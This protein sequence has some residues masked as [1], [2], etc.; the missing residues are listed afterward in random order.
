MI[1][2]ICTHMNFCKVH[3]NYIWNDIY[4]CHVKWY[5]PTRL[6][7]ATDT[8]SSHSCIFCSRCIYQYTNYCNS[9]PKITLTV[10][11]MTYQHIHVIIYDISISSSYGHRNLLWTTITYTTISTFMKFYSYKWPKHLQQF[12]TEKWLNMSNEIYLP[13]SDNHHPLLLQ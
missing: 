11:K 6:S 1:T 3:I 9:I 12:S 7:S 10:P 13:Y 8:V 4:T 5:I 2:K